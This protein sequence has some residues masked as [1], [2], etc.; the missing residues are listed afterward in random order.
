[1]LTILSTSILFPVSTHMLD[2]KLQRIEVFR[3]REETA[4][5]L[6][7]ARITTVKG[8]GKVT[9]LGLI[10]AGIWEYYVGVKV[11]AQWA[12]IAALEKSMVFSLA[13]WATSGFDV[14]DLGG[15]GGM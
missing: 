1:M 8:R 14:W 12:G 11:R 10:L 15:G 6:L 7:P 13:V 9:V 5:P 2:G 4:S 3:V